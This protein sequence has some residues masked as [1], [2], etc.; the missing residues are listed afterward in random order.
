MAR[1]PNIKKVEAIY[2]KVE[3]YPGKRACC[4]ARLLRL[5]RSDVTRSLPVL[6][7]RGFLLSE[8][9]KGALWPFRREP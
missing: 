7:Q 4:I 5:P 9:E 1:K 2:R 8:D 6:E 3:Q